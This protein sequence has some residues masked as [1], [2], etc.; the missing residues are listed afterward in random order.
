MA[1]AAAM[2]SMERPT[3]SASGDVVSRWRMMLLLQVASTSA[4]NVNTRA[5]GRL[6]RVATVRPSQ[7]ASSADRACATTSRIV[8]TSI[9]APRAP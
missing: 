7:T 8:G 3:A 6:E 4:M 2:S 9:A 1:R 5:T